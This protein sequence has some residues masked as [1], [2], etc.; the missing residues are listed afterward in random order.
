M[1]T[2]T[3]NDFPSLIINPDQTDN[4]I[5]PDQCNFMELIQQSRC[6]ADNTLFI[7]EILEIKAKTVQ[8]VSPRKWGKT[9]N[10]DMLK[11]FLKIPTDEFGNRRPLNQTSAY[12]LFKYGKLPNGHHLLKPPLISHRQL[13][14]RWIGQ[15]PVITVSLEGSTAAAFDSI[16]SVKTFVRTKIRNTFSEHVY[17]KK[18]LQQLID[19]S[20]CENQSKTAQLGLQYYAKIEDDTATDKE[21]RR[22]IYKL[23]E[24]L[25][26][27]FN[28]HVFL[29]IDDYDSI[30]SNIFLSN[31]TGKKEAARF[32]Y[33][34]VTLALNNNRFSHQALL[35]GTFRICSQNA[36]PW[37]LHNIEPYEFLDSYIFN[38]FAINEHHFEEMCRYLDITG[39][40]KTSIRSWYAGYRAGENSS[41]NIYH[42]WNLAM[43]FRHKSLQ[44]YCEKEE[45][46]IEKMLPTLL[47]DEYVA[48]VLSIILSGHVFSVYVEKTDP[49]RLTTSDF[50]IISLKFNE[51][52]RD[53]YSCGNLIIKFLLATGYL[54]LCND[55]NI[56]NYYISNPEQNVISFHVQLPNRDVELKIR[57]Y[58]AELYRKSFGMTDKLTL[59]NASVELAKE[60]SSF[61]YSNEEKNPN[62]TKV[63]KIEQ[64][65]ASFLDQMALFDDGKELEQNQTDTVTLNEDLM[66]SIIN[67]LLAFSSGIFKFIYYKVQY[68]AGKKPGVL[69]ICND[70]VTL[71]DFKIILPRRKP[72]RKPTLVPHFTEFTFIYTESPNSTS[73][74]N[75]SSQES[76]MQD[77]SS[78]NASLQ[79][80]SLKDTSFQDTSLQDISG[81][82]DTKVQT[83]SPKTKPP[84]K[85]LQSKPTKS[86][87]TKPQ[88]TKS[89][90][91]TLGFIKFTRFRNTKSTGTNFQSTKFFNRTRFTKLINTKSPFLLSTTERANKTTKM[92]L[93]SLT[94][95]KKLVDNYLYFQLKMDAA[96]KIRFI[97]FQVFLN[98]TV[99]VSAKTE[100]YDEQGNVIP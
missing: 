19:N 4:I 99:I 39:E 78:Q 81:L 55:F 98:K 96:K 1:E 68:T 31:I 38:H 94:V 2:T 76:S 15:Y 35:T 49:F 56:Y 42:P 71:I 74:R 60:F 82:Q 77:A 48:R 43:Y 28:K 90:N 5:T 69:L 85:N 58:F 36:M 11:T 50:R 13:V 66:Y 87:Y 18:G 53:D 30:I 62:Q 73:S 26:R 63:L 86:Q 89:D 46:Y 92:D 27:F 80:T 22:S 47:Q 6:L 40:T 12:H 61:V 91:S 52:T 10:L 34:I 88:Y 72:K 14:D 83:K 67:S 23:S 24:I 33:D 37:G 54:T 70:Y 7:E 45:S 20:K 8:I 32:C 25:Y 17:L 95:K 57:D 84:N 93:D 29:L 65:F 9:T 44:C 51:L 41:L 79:D 100:E 16:D 3:Q 59:Q 97:E 64:S 75:E 21:F